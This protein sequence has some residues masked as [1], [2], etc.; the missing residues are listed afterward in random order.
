MLIDCGAGTVDVFKHTRTRLD[1]TTAHDED[2]QEGRYFSVEW[3]HVRYT[4]AGQ[5]ITKSCLHMHKQ[6]PL[7]KYLPKRS[8]IDEFPETD[9]CSVSPSG[10]EGFYNIGNAV[11]CPV[12]LPENDTDAILRTKTR[13]Y[14]YYT[15]ECRPYQVCFDS[16]RAELRRNYLV[17]VSDI[18]TGWGI[19]KARCLT[20]WK[21]TTFRLSK[22]A[23]GVLFLET[24]NRV[25]TS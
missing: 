7:Q 22:K 9:C 18:Q 10:C 8:R 5:Q 23:G 13:T 11:I 15:E 14:Q 21:D 6:Y 4:F 25:G 20:T 2:D 17:G 19:E 16:K 24:R 1:L 3:Q 12:R